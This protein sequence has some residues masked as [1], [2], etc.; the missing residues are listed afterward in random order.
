MF[1]SPA[2]SS[3]LDFDLI[4][5][6]SALVGT[7]LAAALAH[8]PLRIA[9]LDAQA[10]TPPPPV[11]LND[12]DARIY[13][14]NPGNMHF[15]AACGAWAHLPPARLQTIH[16][17]DVKGDTNG[18]L[19]FDSYRAGVP[20]LAT[21]VEARTLQHALDRSLVDAPNVTVLRPARAANLT[22]HADHASLTLQTGSTL[23]AQL[24][25]GADGG[26]SWVRSQLEAHTG[27]P[28]AAL[29]YQHQGVVANFE[30]STPHRD[31]AYQ[32]FQADGGVL[33]Y[34]PLPGLRMSMV[35]STPNAH[36]DYLK[37]LS[38]EALCTAVAAA[39]AHQ[40][41]DLRLLTPAAAFPLNALVPPAITHARLALIGDA[42][43]LVHPLAGQ[44]VNLGFADAAALADLLRKLP[45]R[46]DLGHPAL[47]SRYARQRSMD[48][49][50]MHTLTRGLQQLFKQSNPLTQHARN[51]GLN[52]VNHAGGLR[53]SLIRHALG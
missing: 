48:V 38:P 4:I 2:S 43:H 21:T 12:W 39:G 14:I 15:L 46:A 8:S 23:R 5:V 31:T 42:A 45:A 28:S 10:L 47:L 36:A 6:G 50:A 44:G 40:L 19:C 20:A 9:L 16:C 32:W 26:R 7:S 37:Q 11:D 51:M 35:W 27:A 34:L 1:T 22:V 13:A 3:P 49:N 24:I 17:M 52:L 41:G 30:I 25:V 53:N 29:P 33:A 18:N